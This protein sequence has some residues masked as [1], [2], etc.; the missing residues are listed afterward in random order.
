MKKKITIIIVIVIVV[1][2]LCIYFSVDKGINEVKSVS[3]NQVT[4]NVEGLNDIEKRFTGNK[5]QSWTG[6][7]RAT[8]MWNRKP[9]VHRKLLKHP[10]LQIKLKTIYSLQT[11]VTLKMILT[12]HLNF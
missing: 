10:N 12:Q 3:F 7:Q 9:E 8:I 4:I 2:G 11:M 1:I 5:L 6:G